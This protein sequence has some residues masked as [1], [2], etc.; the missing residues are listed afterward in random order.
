VYL[1]YFCSLNVV[2][3][4]NEDEAT[5]TC[6]VCGE[7]IDK[8][9][10]NCSKCEDYD[11]CEPCFIQGTDDDEE[12]RPRHPHKLTAI[13]L[14]VKASV[15]FSYTSSNGN[16]VH[17]GN[18]ACALPGSAVLK[19][20]N[21]GAVLSLIELPHP[22]REITPLAQL[23]SDG[24]DNTVDGVVY[25]HLAV[26]DIANPAL[27]GPEGAMALFPETTSFISES[28]KAKRNVLVHCELGQRRYAMLLVTQGVPSAHVA[29]LEY[30]ATLDRL[31]R[32]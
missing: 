1:V 30:F 5:F 25:H 27:I 7:E 28:L 10:Y 16:S 19:Q 15:M 2:L 29:N 3:G 23:Y 24:S 9:R 31:S 12:E 17:V 11:I 32:S 18:F 6:D 8:I 13:K 20:K 4:R 22:N 21:I 14:P 26:A